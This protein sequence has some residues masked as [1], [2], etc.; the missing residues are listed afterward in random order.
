MVGWFPGPH[1][2]LNPTS[3]LRRLV[4]YLL[5]LLIREME[6]WQVERGIHGRN[7]SPNLASDLR[8]LYDVPTHSKMVEEGWEQCSQNVDVNGPHHGPYQLMASSSL[9]RHRFVE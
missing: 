4:F 5:F 2:F 8:R 9:H 1:V 3:D 6:R 7:V